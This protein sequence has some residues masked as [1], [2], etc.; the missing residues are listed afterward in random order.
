VL[1]IGAGDMV[2]LS[3]KY[4]K[5][6]LPQRPIVLTNRSIEKA[7]LLAEEFGTDYF[8]YGELEAKMPHFTA[9]ISA[10]Q[11]EQPV[12]DTAYLSKKQPALLFDLGIPC[13][14]TSEV[15]S[16][17]RYYDLDTIAEFSAS[18]LKQRTEDA[19]KVASIVD[20]Q[21]S[22]FEDWERRRVHYRKL[23][24]IG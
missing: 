15:A 9:I 5:M 13:N 18:T 2:K 20:E 1:L 3:L 11:V 10:I 19:R 22:Q 12:F 17:H 8:H 24:E 14:F 23:V 6:V 4:L 21:V 7:R 16:S